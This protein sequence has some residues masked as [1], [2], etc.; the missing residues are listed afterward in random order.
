VARAFFLILALVSL[1]LLSS[2]AAIAQVNNR[3]SPREPVNV[4]QGGGS[5]FFRAMLHLHGIKPVTTDELLQLRKYDDVIVVVLG[6]PDQSHNRF[7]RLPNEVAKYAIQNGG[8]VLIA[9]R[10]AY[11]FEMGGITIHN[12]DDTVNCKLNSSIFRGQ[13]IDCPFAVPT[14]IKRGFVGDAIQKEVQK[15]FNGDSMELQN[16]KHVVAGT[17]SYITLQGDNTQS[18]VPLAKFPDKSV[19]TSNRNKAFSLTGDNYFSVG[20]EWH[21]NQ[22]NKASRLVAL[23]STEVF[24]NELLRLAA[25]EKEDEDPTDN[26]ELCFRTIEYLQGPNQERKRCVFFVN[27][28]IV[29]HFDDLARATAT[30]QIPLP[31]TNM[32][33]LQKNLIDKGNAIIDSVQQKDVLNSAIKKLS[34]SA[35]HWVVLTVLWLAA[36][37]ACLFIVRRVFGSRKPTDLPPPPTI[38]SATSGPPGVFER[39]EKELLRRDNVY[40]P[41]RDLIRDFFVSVGVQNDPGPRLPKLNISRAIRKPDSLRLALRDLWRLAYGPTSV[42]SVSQ[43]RD[44]EPYFERVQKAHA[45]KK[46]AFAFEAVV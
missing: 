21:H 36:I 7:G 30:Q 3:A 26:L 19:A 20:G 32:V 22:N 41:V 44:L 14:A 40:E 6:I 23:A 4:L 45:D 46:W 1:T 9:S 35:W 16:L 39:R 5:E 29:E 28:F 11:E 2:S 13:H 10:S 25:P 33:N 12:H 18:L 24:N 15:L 27:G 37:S 34:P 43:W 42:V 17:P 31:R 8:A 38:A